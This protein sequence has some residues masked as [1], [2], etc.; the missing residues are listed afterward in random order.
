MGGGR[1]FPFPKYVWTPYGGWWADPKNWKR[2]TAFVMI[3]GWGISAIMYYF[4]EKNTLHYAR[5]APPYQF[6]PVDQ[7][8]EGQSNSHH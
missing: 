5:E 2:N 8:G 3:G 4:A 7:R 6:I 1:R